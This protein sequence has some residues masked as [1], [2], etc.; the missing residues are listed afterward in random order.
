MISVAKLVR[1]FSSA[2]WSGIS[3]K[4]PND[5]NKKTEIPLKISAKNITQNQRIVFE[6]LADIFFLFTMITAYLLNGSTLKPT[7]IIPS[8]I[9]IPLGFSRSRMAC[10]IWTL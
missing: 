6:K 1:G 8:S 7:S 3:P 10:C 2:V 9:A 5:A 4:T